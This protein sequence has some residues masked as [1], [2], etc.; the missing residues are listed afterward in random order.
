MSS[1]R[2][3]GTTASLQSRLTRIL[4][5]GCGALLLLTGLVLNRFVES[6]MHADFDR[7]LAS[8]A[9]ALISLTEQTEG[10]VEFDFVDELMPEFGESEDE[11]GEEDDPNEAGEDDEDDDEDEISPAYF[12]LWVDAAGGSDRVFERSPSLGEANLGREIDR[13]AQA[14]FQDVMLPSDEHGR[15][16]QLDFV[17]QVEAPEDEID[18]ATGLER[19]EPGV[20]GLDPTAE[21]A[22]Y[23]VATLVVARST[24]PLSQRISVFRST[25][26]GS[27]LLLLLLLATLIHLSVRSGLRPLRDVTA[28]VESLGADRLGQRIDA[29]APQEI[30]PLVARVNELLDRLQAAFD[31]ERRFSSDVAHELRTPIAELRSLA[32]VGGRWPDDRIAVRQF[33][34]DAQAIAEQME[35][36]VTQLLVVARTEAGIETVEVERID[37][38]SRVDAAL[39]LHEAAASKKDLTLESDVA[40]NLWLDTDDGKLE[41]ILHNLLGNAVTYSPEGT[42]I[43]VEAR[44][45]TGNRLELSVENVSDHLADA[46]L[47]RL[48]DRFWRKDEARATPGSSGLGLALVKGLSDLMGVDVEPTIQ[49]GIFR[50]ELRFPEGSAGYVAQRA[51]S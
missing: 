1:N 10:V 21:G 3:T 28:Q 42:A 22:D 23:R 7:A 13:S 37:L 29:E 31:R 45:A 41:L 8:Q 25:L 19:N 17:P 34:G 39:H 14:R 40:R 44:L 38:A 27:G 20:T 32:E 50:L 18:E 30:E 43:R 48:F 26:A 36:V 5:V 49:A 46:D 51:A 9:H 35:Q 6:W 15:S 33:F 4:L 47:P 16:V 2:P 24:E 11:E 12:Q